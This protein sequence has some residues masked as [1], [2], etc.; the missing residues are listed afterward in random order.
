MFPL[1]V[2]FSQGESTAPYALRS[3]LHFQHKAVWYAATD[4]FYP[5]QSVHEI[6][7]AP[8]S[9]HTHH[10]R[11]RDHGLSRSR[12]HFTGHRTLRVKATRSPETHIRRA[13]DDHKTVN[14]TGRN[15]RDRFRVC[16]L[17]S[18]RQ[19]TQDAGSNRRSASDQFC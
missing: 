18:R 16:V 15:L 8:S 3:A 14:T 13:K 2:G 6:N 4:L 17:T 19:Q 10:H 9:H 12:V 7:R 11:H 5:K 1:T